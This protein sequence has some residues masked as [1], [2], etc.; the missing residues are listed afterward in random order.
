MPEFYHWCVIN[1]ITTYCSVMQK[2]VCLNWYFKN[3][4]K[5]V[6]IL[7]AIYKDQLSGETYYNFIFLPLIFL[8]RCLTLCLPSKA[9][10]LVEI[11][12]GEVFKVLRCYQGCKRY[13]KERKEDHKPE[14]IF[15][16][17]HIPLNAALNIETG[18]SYSD[19]VANNEKY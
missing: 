4:I 12:E 8:Y 11:P 15:L 19:V 16:V 18:L 9:L 7:K 1:E 17:M 5:P 3:M 10:I 13:H 6:W 2:V 14:S